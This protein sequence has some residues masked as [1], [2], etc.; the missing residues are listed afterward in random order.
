MLPTIDSESF[1]R[2]HIAAEAIDP[3]GRDRVVSAPLPSA[4]LADLERWRWVSGRW[5]ATPDYR[6]HS[7]Y[8]P[9]STDEVFR[10]SR[11]DEAPPAGWA[12]WLPGTSRTVGQAEA[13]RKKWIEVRKQRDSLLAASDWIVARS[14][15][16]G[17]P[18]PRDWAEYR[19]ALRDITAQGSD[20]F[21]L[22]WPTRPGSALGAASSPGRL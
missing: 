10:A 5:V 4:P 20:P 8:N 17:Q 19:Q 16:R 15:E 6:G 14:S 21:S 18:T 3:A 11:F 2:G 9:D 13:V 1:H 22:T 12:R 7:W